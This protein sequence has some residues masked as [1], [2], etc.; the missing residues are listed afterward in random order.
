MILK[1]ENITKAYKSSADAFR[2][3]IDDFVIEEGSFTAILGPNG[4]GKSTFLKV[5]LD[6][7]FADT[8]HITLM[9]K[10]H[11]NKESRVKLSYLPE[12][13]SLP[14]NFTVRE[15][16]Q[17]FA[18]LKKSPPENLDLRIE[19]L[20]DA[21][22]VNYLD[23][24]VKGLSK[25]MTQ[26]TALMNTFLSDDQFYILDEPFNGLDAVKKKGIMDYIFHLQDKRNISI[27]IT[28][29]ILSDID[30]TCDHLHLIKDGQII[31]EASKSEL[32]D[33][34]DTVESFYLHH[35]ENKEPITS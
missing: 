24:K 29:H 11:K 6:L 27:L 28:T 8:G 33:Q 18:G 1:A 3:K 12:N 13:F 5:I 2:L 23:K 30:K 26:I 15:V 34:F 22:D 14:K 4:S 21:F 16:L 17:S 9:G 25:G 7:L 20:A 31:E 19:E 32:Q 35:F 10:S